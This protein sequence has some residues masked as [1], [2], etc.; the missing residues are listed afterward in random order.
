V[1]EKRRKKRW[2][3]TVLAV[4]LIAT[5]GYVVYDTWQKGITMRAEAQAPVGET[6][7]VRR[8][9]LQVTVDAT[10]S[11]APLAEVSL[12]F[13]S[14]GRVIEILV[15]EGQRV[16]AGDVLARLDDADAREAV[17]EAEFQIT[18][19]EIE[20]AL[21]QIRAEAE[22]A[23]AD[24]EAAQAGYE[25]TAILAERVGDQLTSA[26]V[27][28]AQARDELAY[29]QEDYDTAWDSARDWELDIESK[30]DALEAERETTKRALEDAQYNLQVAQADYNLAVAST[31]DD[32]VQN[33]WTQVL[34]AQ[35]SLESESLEL[36][37]LELSLAQ[38]QLGLESARR[39]LDD[40]VLV[41][42]AA[43]T[44]TELNVQV[45]EM[46]SAGQVAVVVIS[47]LS[48][49]TVDVN[50]DETD[51]ALVSVGQ[52]VLASV[53]AFPD[54]ELAGK[55]TYIAPIAE[56]QSGVVLYPVTIRLSPAD[57]PVRAGMTADV[58]ITIDSQEDA[59]VVP[60]RAV[61]TEGGHSY[62]N[63]VTGGQTRRVEVALGLVTDTEVEI[64]SGLS[65]GDVVSVV[66]APTQGST[67][68]GFGPGAIFGGGGE[69]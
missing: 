35:V 49:L 26:R 68:R 32:D 56:T 4:V 57:V 16:E 37:Q 61:S 40:T 23:Q 43:G 46:V 7:V 2:W 45:G 42:P 29:A 9:T 18:Q 12:A 20:L 47:D 50:L 60:L 19:A 1:K 24:L 58:E 38:A 22:V 55:V 69:D 8:D 10:G 53:D 54:V 28:L 30:K 52:E 63:R 59:L 33:A 51:V 62:V 65:Q 13:S 21:A 44:I 66:A 67:E 64:T 3:V 41:A 31:D 34:D 5:V 17:V 11:L 48:V 14:G 27:N 39:A 15:E 6:A 36:E 25:E